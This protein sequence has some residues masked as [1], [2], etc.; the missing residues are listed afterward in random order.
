MAVATIIPKG[1]RIEGTSGLIIEF[2]GSR[3]QSHSLSAEVTK[4]RTEEGVDIADHINVG[5]EP[6][7]FTGIVT[8]TPLD[9]ESNPAAEIEAWDTLLDM[10]KSKKLFT[11]ETSL[12]LYTNMACTSVSTTKDKSQRIL[13]VDLSFE[14]VRQVNQETVSLPPEVIKRKAQQASGPKEQDKGKQ[15]T[16]E[17][18]ESQEKTI[19]EKFEER[20]AERRRLEGRQ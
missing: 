5:S 12:R 11:I 4:H 9:G 3:S 18:T 20:L 6:L 1:P 17:A 10:V 15:Q 16:E 19:V 8:A 2:D 13:F 14:E 7:N